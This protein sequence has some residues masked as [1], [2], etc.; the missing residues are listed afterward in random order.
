MKRFCTQTCFWAGRLWK[1]GE[2]VEIGP[3]ETFPEAFFVESAPVKKETVRQ[4]G[5]KDRSSSFNF[6]QV[7]HAEAEAVVPAEKRPADDLASASQPEL[8]SARR[9]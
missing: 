5:V 9:R 1:P 6:V 3:K 2:A 8:P 4:P 7:M